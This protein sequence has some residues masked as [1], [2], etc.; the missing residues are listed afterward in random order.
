MLNL[1]TSGGLGDAAMSF[2][3]ADAL[4]IPKDQFIITHARVRKDSL[5]KPILD[6]YKSQ[7]VR[8][9][10]M[11]LIN[12]TE[13]HDGEYLDGLILLVVLTRLKNHLIRIVSINS[14]TYFLILL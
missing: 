3:K 1:L 11:R 6:F 9:R 2:A 4:N 8:A 7:G 10:I 14:L 5:D 12:N 13:M